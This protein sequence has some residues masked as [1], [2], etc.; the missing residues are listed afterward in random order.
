MKEREHEPAEALEPEVP[1]LGEGR[2]AQKVFHQR[3]IVASGP[4]SNADASAEAIPP[5]LT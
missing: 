1:R 3:R 5:C 4:C 2:G